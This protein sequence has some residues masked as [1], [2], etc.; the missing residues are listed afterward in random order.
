ME[1]QKQSNGEIVKYLEFQNHFIFYE[2]LSHTLIS[3]CHPHVDN[4]YFLL[5]DEKIW[6]SEFK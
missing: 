3:S 2:I 5:T 4:C 6:S 1:T